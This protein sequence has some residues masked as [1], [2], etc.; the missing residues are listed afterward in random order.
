M[1]DLRRALTEPG[2]L[3]DGWTAEHR[4]GLHWTVTGPDGNSQLVTTDLRS[5]DYDGAN[6]AWFGLGSPWWPS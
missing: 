3:P 4:G 5:Y 1:A 6:V 2:L